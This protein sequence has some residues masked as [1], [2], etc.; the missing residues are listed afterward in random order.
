[1]ILR[2]FYVLCAV[3]VAADFVIHRHVYHPWENL[4]A[5]YA[6]FGFVACVVLVLIA[7]QMRKVLMRDEDYYDDDRDHGG[8]RDD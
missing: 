7:T 2:V 1:M 8:A 6:I 5:F 4:P 3:L